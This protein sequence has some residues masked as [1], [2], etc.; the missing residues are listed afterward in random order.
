MKSI[1]SKSPVPMYFQLKGIL[2]G[3]ILEKG[4]QKGNNLPSVRALIA[5]Y[6][7][8]LPVVR[9]ALIELEKE[10]IINI[11]KGKGS[12]IVKIPQ[13]PG[14]NVLFLLC[15]RDFLD[16]YFS[17]VLTGVENEAS[18]NG[19]SLIYNSLN[20]HRNLTRTLEK[21]DLAGAIL[22]GEVTM[23]IVNRVKVS[24]IPF[25][26][27]GDIA[28]EGAPSEDINTIA[29]NDSEGA[30]IATKYLIELGHKK[31]AMFTGHKNMFVWK[32]RRKGYEKALKE[33]VLPIKEEYIIECKADT[34]QEGYKA[35]ARLL[36]RL[37][38]SGAL[39]AGNDRYAQG[40][41]RLLNEK[42]LK[43]PDDF[44]IIGFDDLEFAKDL[45]PPLTT[46]RVNMEET[47]RLAFQN[48]LNQINNPNEKPKRKIIPV[49]L[50]ERRSCQ[51]CQKN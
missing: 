41:Y 29:N 35:M 44:S 15:G 21:P 7:V 24:K 37:D 30:Y 47:G 3:Y 18:Q 38:S 16:P 26:V 34:A 9:Q 42:G 25:V 4:L 48:L 43:A 39:F 8:S 40:A 50:I 27:A 6:G 14:K 28:Q 17:R 20:T 22:T 12:Y 36:K 32:E 2:S 5:K 13:N 11:E 19:V 23:D 1:D 51:K 45:I 10:G 46:I 31:I 33:A 49:T